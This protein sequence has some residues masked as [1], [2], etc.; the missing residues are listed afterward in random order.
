MEAVRITYS[1]RTIAMIECMQLET[2]TP[3]L[4]MKYVILR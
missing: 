3:K 4:V 2:G 1:R